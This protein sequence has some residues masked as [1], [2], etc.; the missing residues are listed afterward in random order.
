MWVQ[1][2][3]ATAPRLS[4][5]TSMLLRL[6]GSQAEANTLLGLLLLV[7]PATAAR[8]LAFIKLWPCVPCLLTG[9]LN[10]LMPYA[11]ACSSSL[12]H[13]PATAA[14]P[15]WPDQVQSQLQHTHQMDSCW[16][17]L[18]Q[19]H[20]IQGLCGCA[21]RPPAHASLHQSA[22]H[23]LQQGPRLCT[24]CRSQKSAKA[25]SYICWFCTHVSQS[26]K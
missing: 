21:P 2:L 12:V 7:R 10:F 22:V 4:L 20:G 14:G 23:S 16:G 18:T 26:A 1:V 6:P 25:C 5:S 19:V 15:S 8:L 3:H 24:P 11:A 17:S 13:T 9:L